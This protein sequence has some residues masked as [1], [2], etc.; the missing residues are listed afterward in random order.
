MIVFMYLG[1]G[2]RELCVDGCLSRLSRGQEAN[3]YFQVRHL[4][5]KERNKTSSNAVFLA[6]LHTL[7]PTVSREH[8]R[9][10]QAHQNKITQVSSLHIARYLLPLG[11]RHPKNIQQG[12]KDAAGTQEHQDDA[13][14]AFIFGFSRP[15]L[16]NRESKIAKSEQ[17]L[18]NW[19][20][21]LFVIFFLCLLAR[22]AVGAGV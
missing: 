5:A 8:P 7:R 20:I 1:D 12:G 4:S 15:F 19:E 22:V 3:K 2:G 18:K 21:R 17:L 13:D 10:Q 14:R 16:T 9:A 11:K 6:P